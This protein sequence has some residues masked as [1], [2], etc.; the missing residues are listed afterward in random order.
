MLIRLS[1]LT[2]LTA[3][4][5]G[6]PVNPHQVKTDL[7]LYTLHFHSDEPSAGEPSTFGFHL[8]HEGDAFS[9]ATVNV[10]ALQPETEQ[11]LDEP[12]TFTEDDGALYEAELTYPSAGTWELTVEITG[13][14]GADQAVVAYEVE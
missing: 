8:L 4:S 11:G 6:V 9:G 7:G 12:A 5:A 3:C 10:T 14:P 1:A 2:L 13:E